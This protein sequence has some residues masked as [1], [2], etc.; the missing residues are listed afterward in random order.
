[1]VQLELMLV[2]H[3][4]KREYS[5]VRLAQL[6]LLHQQKIQSKIFITNANRNVNL[7]FNYVNQY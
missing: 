6:I 2:Q 5:K 7:H 3:I 4:T 1:M